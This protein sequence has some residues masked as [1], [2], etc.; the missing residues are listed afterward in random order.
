MSKTEKNGKK[1]TQVKWPKY[2]TP[3]DEQKTHGNSNE[4][5]TSMYYVNIVYID[6]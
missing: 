3:K 2:Q 6:V 4:T 1:I 5:M